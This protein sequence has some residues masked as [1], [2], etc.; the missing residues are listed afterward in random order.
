MS[1][2]TRKSDGKDYYSYA[3]SMELTNEVLERD[4]KILEPEEFY[5]KEPY[6][7][8]IY[9]NEEEMLIKLGKLEDLEEELGID[10]FELLQDFKKQKENLGDITKEV[11]VDYLAHIVLN[12]ISYRKISE[13]LG[14]PLEAVFKAIDKGIKTKKHY[15][16]G[17][18]QEFEEYIECVEP[19]LTFT[20]IE[21]DWLKDMEY[22]KDYANQWCFHF[23]DYRYVEDKANDEYECLVKLSDYQKTWWLKGEKENAD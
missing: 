18:G 21:E 5:K 17:S 1:R 6:Q 12:G 11:E 7:I 23:R 22:F 16:I 9:S 10:V 20:S 13:E 3:R 4:D 14:C 8:D 2:L 19:H 15:D